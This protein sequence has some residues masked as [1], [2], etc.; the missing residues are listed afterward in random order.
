[1][2]VLDQATC[3]NVEVRETA[4]HRLAIL[5]ENGLGGQKTGGNLATCGRYSNAHWS[6][7]G[8]SLPFQ[9]DL[10]IRPA[11]G[12]WTVWSGLVSGRFFFHFIFVVDLFQPLFVT[13]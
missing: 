6:I 11:L 3:E 12:N 7:V 5:A 8:T 10:F 1:M 4:I 9:V 13:P 2:R